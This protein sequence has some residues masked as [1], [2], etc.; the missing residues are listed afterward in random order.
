MKLRLVPLICMTA[1]LISGCKTASAGDS[2]R[3]DS[4]R[5]SATS[6]P[7]SHE[8]RETIAYRWPHYGVEVS[9]SSQVP[10]SLWNMSVRDSQPVI[11]QALAAD[12]AKIWSLSDSKCSLK[13]CLT[14]IDQSLND[15]L[16]EEPDA[17]LDSFEIEN[18]LIKEL[19]G[20]ILSGLHQRLLTLDGRKSGELLD[21]PTEIGTSVES[22][23]R[24][25]ATAEGITTLM[26]KHKM[27][28]DLIDVAEFTL[29]KDSDS[30]RNW[31]EIG[32]S[33]G[34]GILSPGTMEFTLRDAYTAY[35]DTIL[36]I[37]KRAGKLV[38][39]ADLFYDTNFIAF[40]EHSA[41]CASNAVLF[42]KSSENPE[43]AKMIVVYS[44]QRLPLQ[45]YVDFEGKLIDMAESRQISSNFLNRA[46][47]IPVDLSTKVQ[48]NFSNP[49]VKTLIRKIKECP[50][51]NSNNRD[52]YLK[53]VATGKALEDLQEMEEAGM[54]P[55]HS[56]QW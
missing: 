3:E 48:K 21:V 43:D 6:Q 27:R 11:D 17:R 32:A 37:Q 19:W 4:Q 50:Q 7:M 10:G 53:E 54:L 26:R 55:T 42:L 49:G 36:A 28:V 20:E 16:A 13:E 47:L 33:P 9:F 22:V 23:V 25:S 52:Y 14:I 46:I 18:H 45:R 40:Y 29:F 12:E 15:F 24:N 56:S 2:H 31:S 34:M 51:I 44:L 8:R 1:F 41:D 38:T 35:R 5:Q 39:T 30:G